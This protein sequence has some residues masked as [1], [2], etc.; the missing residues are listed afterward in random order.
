[1]ILRKEGKFIDTVSLHKE[2]RAAVPSFVGIYEKDDSLILSRDDG[3]EFTD[4]QTA[5]IQ[6]VFSAHDGLAHLQAETERRQMK[7][8]AI[9]KDPASLTDSERIA[10][11]E[12]YLGIEGGK[13]DG[14]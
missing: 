3:K 10:R 2:L 4:E 1:M 7:D 8:E 5:F 13:K 11:I 12:I 14:G 6:K 9:K